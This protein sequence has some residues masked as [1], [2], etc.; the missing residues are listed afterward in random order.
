MIFFALAMI[1]SGVK[2]LRSLEHA[3]TGQTLDRYDGWRCD[4]HSTTRS[5][6]FLE[7]DVEADQTI[8]PWN[9]HDTS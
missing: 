7:L 4:A 2:V 6:T 1:F 8:F 3:K 5:G 9:D